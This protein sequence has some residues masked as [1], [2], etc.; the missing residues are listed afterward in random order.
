M[1]V[2]RRG[3]ETAPTAQLLRSSRLFS[4]PPPLPRPKQED[5]RGTGVETSD[6]AITPYPTYQIITTPGSSRSRGD[7]GLKRLYLSDLP[8]AL[9]M[10]PSVLPHSIQSNKLPIISRPWITRRRFRS[11]RSYI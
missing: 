1:S 9:P 3:S 11:Y 2:E 10:L 6:T 7:W 4:L 8:A 5:R